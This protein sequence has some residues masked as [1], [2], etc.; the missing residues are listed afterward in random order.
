MTIEYQNK[1]SI[2]QPT[3]NADAKVAGEGSISGT[4]AEHRLLFMKSSTKGGSPI[5][6]VYAELGAVFPSDYWE[7]GGNKPKYKGTVNVNGYDQDLALWAQS[8]NGKAYLSGKV[9][10]K[11]D[12]GSGDTATAP[13]TSASAD[14]I[15]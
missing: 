7:E 4:E 11:Y 8:S 13:T 1:A 3:Y 5:F 15:L 9:S 6:K 10:D 14:S 2:F 12:A